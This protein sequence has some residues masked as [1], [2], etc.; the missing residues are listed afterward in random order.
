MEAEIVFADKPCIGLESEAWTENPLLADVVLTELYNPYHYTSADNARALGV[1]LG[2]M[3]AFS[4]P[5]Y[6]E[7]ARNYAH[8]LARTLM[9]KN[10]LS[11][12]WIET[13]VLQIPFLSLLEI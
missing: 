12:I 6:Q 11:L 13:G 7:T 10:R 2:P 8:L 1:N 5:A 4:D 3:T 9:L